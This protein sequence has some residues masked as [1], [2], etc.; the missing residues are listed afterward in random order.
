MCGYYQNIITAKEKVFFSVQFTSIYRGAGVSVKFLMVG[1]TNFV[2]GYH[3]LTEGH[4]I[5]LGSG[6]GGG[7]VPP[8]PLSGPRQCPDN[9]NNININN[10]I[11][12]VSNKITIKSQPQVPYK[13][14]P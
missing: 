8:S 14:V 10:N 6:G 12:R 3:L 1:E 5:Q 11:F 7:A 4:S 13:K 2:V 9:N